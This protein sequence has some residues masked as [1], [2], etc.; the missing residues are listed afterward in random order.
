VETY[1]IILQGIKKVNDL[2]FPRFSRDW[3]KRFRPAE[4]GV[5]RSRQAAITA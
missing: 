4:A 1:F 5:A 3:A 2:R